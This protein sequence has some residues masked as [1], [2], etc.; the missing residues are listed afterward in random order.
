MKLWLL[1]A[2]E[3]LPNGD[4]PWVPWYNKSFGY[5]VRADTEEE[6]R[7]IAHENAGDENRG[8]FKQR[9]TAKTNQ[10]WEDPKY[11]DCVE[12]TADGERG[13]VLTDFHAA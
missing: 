6:A 8:E 3:G 13:L 2:K 4:N 9:E 12:L 1:Q 5:V 7:N 10:P 11:S